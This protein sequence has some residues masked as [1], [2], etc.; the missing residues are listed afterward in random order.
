MGLYVPKGPIR[1]SAALWQNELMDGAIA[2]FRRVPQ[3]GIDSRQGF[4]QSAEVVG[5]QRPAPARESAGKPAAEGAS[6]P[7]NLS[8]KWTAPAFSNDNL[9]SGFGRMAW[10]HRRGKRAGS[11]E[12]S[13]VR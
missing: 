5:Q 2:A 6:R 8:G 10:P 11:R 4:K 13:Q 7:R 12:N 9:E 1:N 3:R